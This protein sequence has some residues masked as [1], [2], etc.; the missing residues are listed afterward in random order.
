VT[1]NDSLRQWEKR[2][3]QEAER[4]ILTAARI[5]SPAIAATFSD[6]YTWCVDAIK[7][8]IYAQLATDL[9]INKAIQLLKQGD[10]TG[11]RQVLV[12]FDTKDSKVASA[13]ANN[14][15]FLNLLVGTDHDRLLTNI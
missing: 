10:L 5:I 3:R 12:S 7:Q 15:A 4:T 14:L 1:K 6:G 2:R 8:S 11:A 9:E 13:A